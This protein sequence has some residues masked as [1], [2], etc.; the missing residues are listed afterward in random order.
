MKYKIYCKRPKEDWAI[1][2]EVYGFD[3]QTNEIWG[4]DGQLMDFAADERFSGIPAPK[5]TTIA[6]VMSPEQPVIGK[7]R[8]LRS[9][10]IQLG[11]KC[12]YHCSYCLQASFRDLGQSAKPEDAE[13]FIERLTAAGIEVKPKGRIE[14]WGGEPLVYVK[15]LR[16]LIPLLREKFEPGVTISMV[17]N[18]SLLTRELVDF[19]F[20]HRVQIIISHDGTGFSLRND[21]DPLMNPDIKAVWLYAYEKYRETEWPVM[22]NIV[23]SNKNCDLF[24]LRDFF[25]KNFVS[26]AILNFEGVLGNLGVN[27]DNTFTDDATRQLDASVWKALIQEPGEW[28]SLEGAAFELMRMLVHRIPA[29]TAPCRCNMANE[30]SLVTDLKGTIGACQNRPVDLFSIGRLESLETVKNDLMTHWQFRPCRDCLVLSVCKAGCPLLTDGELHASCRNEFALHSAVFG[31][32]WFRLT[33]RILLRAE[34]D[35]TP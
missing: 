24:A 19:F 9:L 25:R 5:R 18:G 31:A 8:V 6:P 23:L 3:N 16:R 7:R 21:R 27:D 13:R 1:P 30:D 26:E 29:G 11:M 12:N 32:V 17:T 10:K 14:L 20:E 2:P 34:V 15:V 33:G 28:G 35:R 22:F 4:P